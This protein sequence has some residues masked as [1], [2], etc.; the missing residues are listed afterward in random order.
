METGPH[1]RTGDRDRHHLGAV[2]PFQDLL[3][4]QSYT[5]H[6]ADRLDLNLEP[7]QVIWLKLQIH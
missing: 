2:K 6:I 1:L 4:E 7:Y 3:T 5:G